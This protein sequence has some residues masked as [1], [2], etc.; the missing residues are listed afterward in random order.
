[1]W[2]GVSIIFGR[3]QDKYP[4][5]CEETRVAIGRG[6]YETLDFWEMSAKAINGYMTG[7]V[8]KLTKAGYFWLD[9]WGSARY[10]TAA[11]FTALV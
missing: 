7:E 9:E 10:N 8:G 11:Q 3:I 1:M 5:I 4:D 2:N 6:Q